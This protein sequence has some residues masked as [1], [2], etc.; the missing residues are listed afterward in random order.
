MCRRLAT[1]I[2][3]AITLRNIFSNNLIQSSILLIESFH[4]KS[5]PPELTSEA[6]IHFIFLFRFKNF[7][8]T[9]DI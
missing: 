2:T 6:G 3:K 1:R 4:K 7:N 9:K 8:F 5:Q